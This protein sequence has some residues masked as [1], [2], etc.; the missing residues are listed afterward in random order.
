MMYLPEF[1]APRVNALQSI[2]VNKSDG[3][4]NA[5]GSVKLNNTELAVSVHLCMCVMMW[6]CLCMYK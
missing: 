4:R 5:L 6:C 1:C 3:W 2:D